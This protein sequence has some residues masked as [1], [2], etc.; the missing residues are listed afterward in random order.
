MTRR[1]N[2]LDSE[3]LD[4]MDRVV[5]SDNLQFASVARSRIDLTDG[6]R[7]SQDFLDCFARF[8]PKVLDVRFGIH[9]LAIDFT[10]PAVRAVGLQC[11]FRGKNQVAAVRRRQFK[12]LGDAH[13]LVGRR[14]R[15]QAAEDTETVIDGDFPG[16]TFVGQGNGPGW[17][18]LGSRSRVP[19][20]VKVE[21]RTSAK[22]LRDLRGLGRIVCGYYS[23]AD[24]LL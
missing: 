9:Q 24:R 13:R 2:E 12:F 22:A 8:L 10:Q 18:H 4:V 20:F 11:V 15:A 23:R 5:Q 17:T 1:G 7:S 19:P 3:A 6:E 14:L 16:I 21:A